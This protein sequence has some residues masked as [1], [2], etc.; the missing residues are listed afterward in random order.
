MRNEKYVKQSKRLSAGILDSNVEYPEIYLDCHSGHIVLMEFE[1]LIEI[2]DQLSP[3][4]L[5]EYRGQVEADISKEV[6]AW[7]T[8][9]LIVAKSAW[10]T[11]NMLLIGFTN[12]MVQH[13]FANRIRRLAELLG[14]SRTFPGDRSQR[15]EDC[16]ISRIKINYVSV[17]RPRLLPVTE[18][19]KIL[20]NKLQMEKVKT[21][22]LSHNFAYGKPS[23]QWVPVS[24]INTGMNVGGQQDGV[25]PNYGE[26]A[27]QALRRVFRDLKLSLRV[28]PTI[29]PITQEWVSVCVKGVT[30]EAF[31]DAYDRSCN[32]DFPTI[33]RQLDMAWEMDV[34]LIHQALHELKHAERGIGPTTNGFVI[35]VRVPV[36]FD[37]LLN[38]SYF[39]QDLEK[40]LRSYSRRFTQRLVLVIKSL[41]SL[42]DQLSPANVK[43]LAQWM[44]ELNAQFGITFMAHFAKPE[45]FRPHGFHACLPFV[46]YEFSDEHQHSR[47]H[48]AIQ[49]AIARTSS[50]PESVPVTLDASFSEEAIETAKRSGTVFVDNVIA[51][52]PEGLQLR[53]LLLLANQIGARNSDH[54]V[55]DARSLFCCD[56][57]RAT[58]AMNDKRG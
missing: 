25:L 8:T 17:T 3:T 52:E 42:H 45:L 57:N 39:R 34:A 37:S 38:W 31:F 29:N 2:A 18:M 51:G 5:Q 13:E 19:S 55:I 16:S 47:L 1:R 10:V 12:L 53:T 4:L 11:T 9:E 27:K 41:D 32:E 54:E 20:L 24:A 33:C 44:P 14:R 15:C 36:S 49:A 6:S 50:E 43:R 35:P 56:E 46:G 30:S 7:A 48:D 40:V 21:W 22:R 26:A 28:I 23:E 58:K